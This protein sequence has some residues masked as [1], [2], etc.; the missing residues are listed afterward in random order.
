MKTLKSVIFAAL[1]CCCA[2]NAQ[3][4]QFPVDVAIR[5]ELSSPLPWILGTT[6]ELRLIVENRSNRDTRGIIRQQILTAGLQDAYNFPGDSCRRNADCE[7]FGTI[8][9][10]T[11]IILA[12]AQ[13]QCILRLQ[14]IQLRGQDYFTRFTYRDLVAP[15]FDPDLTNNSVEVRI[16]LL[17]Q[18]PVQAPISP[19]S[20]GLMGLLVLGLGGWTARKS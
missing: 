16:T 1:A 4:Q 18:P 6:N 8:C 2:F 15:H 7:Q 14:P 11:P 19:L 20:Y 13:A 10:E 12:G 17:A 9:Y 5:S 3:S